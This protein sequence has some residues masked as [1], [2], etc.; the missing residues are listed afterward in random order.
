MKTH[1]E[2]A[3][4]LG[5][6]ARAFPGMIAEHPD[7]EEFWPAFAGVADEIVDSAG[8]ADCEYVHDRVDEMLVEHGKHQSTA[9]PDP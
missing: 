2:L 7:D 3:G 1:A 5:A 9:I 4:M 8:A 6:L